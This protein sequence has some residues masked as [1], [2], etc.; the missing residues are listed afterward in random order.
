MSQNWYYAK[1]DQRQG[2]VTSDQLRA[3]AKSGALNPTDLVWTEGMTDWEKASSVTGLIPAPQNVPPPLK[4]T[5]PVK[6]PSPLTAYID[7]AI[8][9]VPGSPSRQPWYCHWAFLS[10]STLF[11]FPVTL[12]LVCWKST[13]SKR[14]KWAWTGACGVVWLAYV[15][16]NSTERKGA[17]AEQAVVADASGVSSDPPGT[18]KSKTVS[19][20]RRENPIHE[21]TWGNLE[22]FQGNTP[23]QPKTPPPAL[24][25]VTKA[26]PNGDLD[27][28]GPE[29]TDPKLRT[30]LL[31]HVRPEQQLYY[32][33]G[34]C[35]RPL[36]LVLASN[37]LVRVIISCPATFPCPPDQPDD[38]IVFTGSDNPRMHTEVDLPHSKHDDVWKAKW[39]ASDPF[40]LTINYEM[41]W[42][43]RYSGGDHFMR[44]ASTLTITGAVSD[45]EGTVT[46]GHTEIIDQKTNR[47]PTHYIDGFTPVARP[48]DVKLHRV[49]GIGTAF[50]LE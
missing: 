37:R 32:V 30:A 28:P 39:R 50:D 46:T 21:N 1:G 29:D 38:L 8:G 31:T 33:R 18:T 34:I 45:C 4:S 13:Y 9:G 24:S 6:P 19:K 48:I 23:P 41:Q 3:L 2:P 36:Y 10:V 22:P 14:A 17:S 15:S 12:L 5:P 43:D 11:C 49:R 40:D 47:P 25:S 44:L 42:F 7:D 16:S 27:I 20:A 26:S 35:K